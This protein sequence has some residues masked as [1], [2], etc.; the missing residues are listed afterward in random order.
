M[1]PLR[2]SEWWYTPEGDPKQYVAHLEN[3]LNHPY[4]GECP[5]VRTS[6]IVVWPDGNGNFETRN[7]RYTRVHQMSMSEVGLS[8]FNQNS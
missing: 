7:T 6:N 8:E 4:L 2:I 5:D 1:G 3:V